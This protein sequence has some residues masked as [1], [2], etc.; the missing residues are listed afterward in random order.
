MVDEEPETYRLVYLSNNTIILGQLA[1]LNTF[2][3]TLKSP[4][5]VNCNDNKVHFSL[6]FNSMTDSENLPIS[7]LH[8]VSFASP[9][10]TIIDHYLDFIDV[11]VPTSRN[12]STSTASNT[13]ITRHSSITTTVH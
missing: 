5:T 2:G 10:K 12:Q 1:S 9:N 8:I 6:L 4:V 11:V 3:V 13:V 7:S